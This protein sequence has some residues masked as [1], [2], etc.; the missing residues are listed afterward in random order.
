MA[1]DPALPS[2]TNSEASVSGWCT[3]EALDGTSRGEGGP[4]LGAADVA[5]GLSPGGGLALAPGPRRSRPYTPWGCRCPGRRGTFSA[6]GESSVGGS[7]DRSH[8]LRGETS[9]TCSSRRGKPQRDPPTPPG[10]PLPP[11][12]LLPPPPP[13]PPPAPSPFWHL[14]LGRLPPGLTPWE[15]LV[16]GVLACG[17]S[18]PGRQVEGEGAGMGDTGVC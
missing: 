17:A 1:G 18:S 14:C 13:H 16:S 2:V 3:W 7:R 5:P 6:C 9:R 10:L 8:G 4:A 11:I 12:P 15:H